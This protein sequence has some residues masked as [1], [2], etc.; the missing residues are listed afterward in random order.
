MGQGAIVGLGLW[1]LLAF[2]RALERA[3]REG[4]YS[5][6]DWRVLTLL[7][8]RRYPTGSMRRSSVLSLFDGAWRPSSS[9]PPIPFGK[10]TLS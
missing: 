4:P 8:D 1:E 7:I 3:A 6:E 10:P 2:L 9:H 5:D